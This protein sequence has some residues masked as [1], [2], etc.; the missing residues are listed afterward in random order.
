[1][2]CQLFNLKHGTATLSGFRL[3]R[4]ANL[5]NWLEQTNPGE[6]NNSKAFGVNAFKIDGEY[7]ISNQQVTY[8]DLLQILGLMGLRITTALK[9][10]TRMA[11]N[12]MLLALLVK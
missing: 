6:L 1:M 11:I 9:S 3:F 10:M 8:L 5:F 7:L 12:L 2:M 4:R